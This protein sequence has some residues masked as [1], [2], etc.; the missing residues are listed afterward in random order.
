LSFICDFIKH[1]RKNEP[2]NWD[3]LCVNNEIYGINRVAFETFVD[4]ELRN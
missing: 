1:V 4:K 2:E 3:K